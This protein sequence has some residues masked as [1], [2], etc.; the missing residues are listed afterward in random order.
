MR[1]INLIIIEDSVDDTLLILNELKKGG[2]D[3]FHVRLETE[4]ALEETIKEDKWDLVISDHALPYF[5][6]P[7]AL[8]TVNKS[9]KELPFIIVSSVIGE[10]VAV[11]AMKAGADDY[12]MKSDLGRLVPVVER[13]GFR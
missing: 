13:T 10:D 2:Y 3:P 8:Y 7:Q 1:R 12:I 6:A 11:V 9:G 4:Q 5:S